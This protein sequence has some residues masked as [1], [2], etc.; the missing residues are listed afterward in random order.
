MKSSRLLPLG[1]LGASLFGQAYFPASDGA[2]ETVTPAEAGADPA[3]LA[4]AEA[5][6]AD[7]G[8]DALIILQGG[9]IVS[10]RYWNGTTRDTRMPLFSASKPMVASVAGRLLEAGVFISLDQPAS[11]F[12]TEWRGDPVKEAITLRQHLSMTTGLEGGEANLVRSLLARSERFFAANLPLAHE[13]GTFWTYNNPAYRLLFPIVQEA[14][15]SD[16]PEVFAERLFDPVGMSAAGWVARP[17]QVGAITV[18]NYQFIEASAL[19]AARFGLL[20]LR[21]GEW[22]GTP[23]V[24]AD[25]M[26]EAV[27][28]SQSLNPSYGYLWWLNGGAEAGGHQQLFDGLDRAGPY[29][30]DAPPDAYAALGKGDQMI[31]VVPSLDLVV[32]RLGAAPLGVGTEAVS[33]EQDVLLGKIS[34][35]FGYEGQEQPLRLGIEAADAAVRLSWPTWIGRNYD[36]LAADELRTESFESVTGEPIPGD[37]LSR[38]VEQPIDS[39]V[40][41]FRLRV[42]R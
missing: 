29:F 28:P 8:S 18:D 41:F 40:R 16:L 19:A 31:V 20:A 10:E 7:S 9:R 5:Y 30:P 39:R 2:W 14:T 22:D 15:G 4:E 35:A 12:L 11:D 32:V 33:P 21:G 42:T 37:G 23:V 17:E 38:A 26:A 3:L 36:L 27:S 24:P 1:F 6:A 34:R 13:P 25:F